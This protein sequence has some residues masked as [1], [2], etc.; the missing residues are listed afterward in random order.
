MHAS[1]LIELLLLNESVLIGIAP[2]ETTPWPIV[3]LFRRAREHGILSLMSIAFHV[4]ACIHSIVRIPMRPFIHTDPPSS[5]TGVFIHLHG[6]VVF[7]RDC[8]RRRRHRHGQR[9]HKAGAS[10]IRIHSL[11]SNVSSFMCLLQRTSF[12]SSLVLIH[13]KCRLQLKCRLPLQPRQCSIMIPPP[14]PPPSWPHPPP[15]AA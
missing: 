6:R 8:C 11:A 1:I 9:L 15:A 10:F 13:L 12:I 5:A 7:M 4:F 14:P 3:C 2:C